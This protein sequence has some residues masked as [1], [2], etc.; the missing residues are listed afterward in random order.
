MK[1]SKKVISAHK[2]SVVVDEKDKEKRDEIWKKLH[3]IERADVNARNVASSVLFTNSYLNGNKHVKITYT[4]GSGSELVAPQSIVYPFMADEVKKVE[5]LTGI[6]I[7]TT[8]I[9]NA[10]PLVTKGFNTDMKEVYKKGWT[11]SLRSYKRNQP[12]YFGADEMKD[13]R[14]AE[15][16]D[17]KGNTYTDL[18]FTLHGMPFRSFFG[19]DA[20]GN[21]NT[22]EH[23]LA[24]MPYVKRVSNGEEIRKDIA[25]YLSAGSTAVGK[26]FA[27]EL[28]GKDIAER[29]LAD[30]AFMQQIRKGELKD[31]EIKKGIVAR[32]LIDKVV[33]KT[34]GIQL[35]R[36]GGRMTLILVVETPAKDYPLSSTKHIVAYI[37]PDV[38]I[39]AVKGVERKREKYTYENIGNA[40]EYFTHRLAIQDARRRLQAAAKYCRGGHGRKRK[41]RC[42][43]KLRDA[44]NR[45]VST[46]THTWA[47]LLV[48]YAVRNGCGTIILMKPETIMEE[49][50]G[51][52]KNAYP[53]MLRNWSF[54]SLIGKIKYKADAAGIKVVEMEGDK[55]SKDIAAAIP[56]WE[57][58]LHWRSDQMDDAKRDAAKWHAPHKSSDKDIEEMN[59][60]LEVKVNTPAPVAVT[61]PRKKKKAKVAEQQ[62]L[63]F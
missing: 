43:N 24:D 55:L 51:K 12:I 9:N 45:Y 35:G 54:G 11:R 16:A 39:R 61:K 20:S 6:T 36:D 63:P 2:I 56:A 27:D 33:M 50:D 57:D 59:A 22:V 38:P 21:R 29:I 28:I 14:L 32:M 49:I 41:Y 62:L 3:A 10:K 53:Y 5:E 7:G 58:F 26:T 42:V 60:E 18:F 34:S 4:G 13:F 44:E 37:A 40:D 8:Y 47:R 23:I 15:H 17:D 30:K 25:S 52:K 19:R 46:A 1:K 48:D 31:K